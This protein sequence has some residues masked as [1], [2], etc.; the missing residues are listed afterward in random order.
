[1]KTDKR[2][3]PKGPPG[4]TVTIT[5]RITRGQREALHAMVPKCWSCHSLEDLLRLLIRAAL[6]AAAAVEERH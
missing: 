6:N 5:V 3:A 1:M 4:E 2:R